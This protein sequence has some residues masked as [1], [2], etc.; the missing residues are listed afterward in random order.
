MS[1]RCPLLRSGKL[2]G[3]IFNELILVKVV[4]CNCSSKVSI[5]VSRVLVRTLVEMVDR[6]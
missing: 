5:R 2:V 3:N 1:D 6:G 4:R